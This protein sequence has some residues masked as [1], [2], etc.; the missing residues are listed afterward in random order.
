MKNNG[1]NV[2]RT[3]FL[4]HRLGY[5]DFICLSLIL[6]RCLL[7]SIAK[8]YRCKW[9]VGSNIDKFGKHIF[10][11]TWSKHKIFLKRQSNIRPH[12]WKLNIHSVSIFFRMHSLSSPIRYL[13]PKIIPSRLIRWTYFSV[14]NVCTDLMQCLAVCHQALE[15][16]NLIHFSL[17]PSLPSKG[18]KTKFTCHPF[19]SHKY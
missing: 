7:E 18:K 10:P 8:A 9:A 16:K 3:H 1:T 4:Y 5:S 14:Q 6:S 17:P 12:I 19:I 13:K 15:K 11:F 2:L